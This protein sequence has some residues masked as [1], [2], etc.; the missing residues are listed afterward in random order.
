MMQKVVLLL[1]VCG[2]AFQLQGQ[3]RYQKF[4]DVAKQHAAVEGMMTDD[5]VRTG[6]W[7]WWHQNGRVYQQGS[8]NSRGEKIGT[9]N[10]FYEDGAKCAV[11]NYE[12]GY[13][14]EWYHDGTLKSEVLVVDRHKQG[15]YKSWYANGQQKDE[16]PFVKGVKQ[17]ATREWH[18]NGQLKFQGTYK[19][20]EL[21]GPATWWTETG[22]VDMKGTLQNGE[23]QGEWLFYWRTNGRIGIR[24]NYE[25]G[26]ET[27]TW[28]YYYETGEKWREGDY[29]NGNK[30]GRWTTWYESGHKLHEG[31]VSIMLALSAKAK[32]MVLGKAFT[33]TVVSAIP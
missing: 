15:T 2:M 17:G 31:A 22:K 20:N 7:T 21:N 29:V 30:E 33:T 26:K 1:A 16:I 10:I 19:D 28:T 3:I 4:Y 14:R 32:N 12:H 8:Y 11:E 25:R 24:G 9:W 6:V 23:Q 27:G 5:S 18:E 13:T